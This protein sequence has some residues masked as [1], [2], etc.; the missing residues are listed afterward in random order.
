MLRQLILDVETKTTFDAVGGY[1]P[2]KLGISFIG[3]I[4]RLGFPETGEGLETRYEL[5]EPDL[6]KLWPVMEQADVLIGFNLDSFDL[7]AISAYYPGDLKRFPTLDL[8]TVIKDQIGH[9]VS[10]DAL[11]KE[12]LGLQ[13]FGV[14]LDAIK[15]YEQGQLEKLARYCMRDVEITRDLYDHGRRHKTV[16]FLSHWNNLVEVP[17]NFDFSPSPTSGTQMSLV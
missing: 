9:R 1:F 11:A 6:K 16:K 10:L 13:K 7:P 4:D 17:V 2:E 8:L 3:A 14:G 12:T 5:F 15:Y